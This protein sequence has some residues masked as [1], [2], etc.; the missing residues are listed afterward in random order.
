M[1]YIPFKGCVKHV[2]VTIPITTE[3]LGPYEIDA[4]TINPDQPIDTAF[5]QTLDFA[6]SGTV[7]AFPFGFGWQQSP[8]FFNSTTTPSSGFFNSGAG[9]ASGFLNDAAAAVSG[10]GNVFTETSGFFNAGGVGNSGFQNFG[11]LLSGWANLGNTVSGF[12]NTSMLDLATQALISGF[13]NHGA[14]L[15]GIP[16]TVADPN[17][18]A[19]RARLPA[20]ANCAVGSPA[21]RARA[22]ARFPD[23]QGGALRHHRDLAALVGT[24]HRQLLSHLLQPGLQRLDLTGQFNNALDAGQVDPLV[25]REVLH[26]AQ[27]LDVM[28]GIAAPATGGAPRADQPKTIVGTQGLCMHAG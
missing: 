15:S 1:I 25:L 26:L 3:H 20:G 2:S 10:L 22:P 8:G 6:G 19:T 18:P 12:Y 28:Q 5:T 21:T 24:Q 14:R 17:S 7:G 27:Q 4:S 23:D 9:G 16:T 13:G 11:N